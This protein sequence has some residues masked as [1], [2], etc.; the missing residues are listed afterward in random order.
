MGIVGRFGWIC[1]LLYNHPF[2]SSQIYIGK[3]KHHATSYFLKNLFWSFFTLQNSYS[4]GQLKVAP[5]LFYWSHNIPLAQLKS[6]GKLIYIV[7]VLYSCFSCSLRFKERIHVVFVQCGL[8]RKLLTT[9]NLC[10]KSKFMWRQPLTWWRNKKLPGQ[11]FS[12]WC[13][14]LQL[15][16]ENSRKIKNLFYILDMWIPGA[17]NLEIC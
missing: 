7:H 3:I 10:W 11:I 6:T 17:Q 4:L 8:F 2:L 13:C 15:D 14:G 1:L 5:I 12:W 9:I 16:A